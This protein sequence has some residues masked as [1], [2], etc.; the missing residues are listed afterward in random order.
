MMLL[1]ALTHEVAFKYC[2]GGL[3]SNNFFTSFLK[4]YFIYLFI[5]AALGLSCCLW[6][7]VPWPGIE[8]GPPALGAWS[9]NHW[10]TREVP[11]F[12]SW[13]AMI[14]SFPLHPAL[15][16]WGGTWFTRVRATWKGQKKK[17]SLPLL[18]KVKI[19]GEPHLGLQEHRREWLLETGVDGPGGGCQSGA[20]SF[21]RW[22]NAACGTLWSSRWPELE[23]QGS[24]WCGPCA[25]I[26]GHREVEKGEPRVHRRHPEQ[27]T[28]KKTSRVV[29]GGMRFIWGHGRR[30]R[31]EEE[32]DMWSVAL[33]FKMHFIQV[34]LIYNAV[35]ISAVQKSWE[36]YPHILEKS[37]HC[38]LVT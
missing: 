16:N 29:F 37:S 32:Q 2:E 10:I 21:S 31:E 3:V 22:V 12:F 14:P 18:T 8:T 15:G 34:W 4:K 11:L 17:S 6:D 27:Q 9:L 23:R 24:F 1:S 33:F 7:L 26:L 13:V 30:S 19:D 25:L 20:G 28:F 5:L 35:L 38:I 36:E